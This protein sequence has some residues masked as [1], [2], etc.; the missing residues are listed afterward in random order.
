VAEY[1]LIGY[2]KG[3]DIEQQVEIKKLMLLFES[4][5]FEKLKPVL[6]NYRKNH[7]NNAL[8]QALRDREQLNNK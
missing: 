1:R 3:V 8:P 2:E 6:Q 5:Q 4:E 7:K